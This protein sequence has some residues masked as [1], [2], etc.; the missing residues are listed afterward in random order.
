LLKDKHKLY[1]YIAGKLAQRLALENVDA[2]IRIDKSKGKQMLQDDFNS[3]F[4]KKLHEFCSVRKVTI[5]H[6]YSQSW[7]G[8]Q[9]AD[10][11]SWSCFQRFERED[12]SYVDLIN[13][14]K[15]DVYLIW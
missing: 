15:L 2:E 7:S 1:N 12:S 8:I 13:G 9:F 4:T 6:S 10:L 11:L 3:Y 14:E 5:F